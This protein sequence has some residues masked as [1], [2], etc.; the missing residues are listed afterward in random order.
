MNH[1]GWLLPIAGLTL[2][3]LLSGAC[4]TSQPIPTATA[5]PPTAMPALST[6]TP[7]PP[8]ATAVPTV[9]ATASP[10]EMASLNPSPPKKQRVL[11][12]LSEQ[13]ID[14]G[15]FLTNEVD[16]M[17]T[18]LSKAGFEVETASDSGETIT[19]GNVTLKPDMKIADVKVE[20]YAG[21]MIP[22]MGRPVGYQ[23]SPETLDVV[24]KAFA[25][26]KWIAAQNY[27]VMVL[28]QAGIMNGKQ[29]AMSETDVGNAAGFKG[30]Y[31]GEGV[32]QDGKIITAGI[33]PYMEIV[34][35]EKGTTIELT[36]KF[37]ES[38]GSQG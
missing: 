12:L 38:L 26:G 31:K 35:G 7:A 36:Q 34:E 37:I 23:A 10:T 16:V 9:A 18:M 14:M 1:K 13:S 20:D 30:V 8:T 27:G 3:V 6:A 22:C 32:V 11:L 5:L 24:R 29:F 4:A 2:V 19:A 33:C 15:L 28:F 21:L 25:E 17:V